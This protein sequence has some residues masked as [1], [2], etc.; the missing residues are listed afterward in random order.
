MYVTVDPDDEG[1]TLFSSGLLAI[2][3]DRLNL[4]FKKK[5]TFYFPVAMSPHFYFHPFYFEATQCSIFMTIPQKPTIAAAADATIFAMF[6]QHKIE[7]IYKTWLK[8]YCCCWYIASFFCF[9]FSS[10][11]SSS[12][13]FCLPPFFRFY[14]SA[15]GRPPGRA[16]K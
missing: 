9:L 2:S 15:L 13:L 7:I 10:Q 3:S 6:T 5:L 14:A 11:S 1:D 16:G 4:F 8:V 12:C